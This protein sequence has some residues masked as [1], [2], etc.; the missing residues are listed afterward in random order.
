M[1][2]LICRKAKA[3]DQTDLQLCVANLERRATIARVSVG[4]TESEMFTAALRWAF[5]VLG[6]LIWLS[7]GFS[8]GSYTKVTPRTC[9]KIYIISM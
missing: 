5:L 1:A 7:V 8:F 2:V 3:N 4:C 6:F 9:F